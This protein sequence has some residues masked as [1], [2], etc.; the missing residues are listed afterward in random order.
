M[1]ES[2]KR[3]AVLTLYDLVLLIGMV[4][5]SLLLFLNETVILNRDKMIAFP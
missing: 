5:F 4:S 1:G 3:L 2:V